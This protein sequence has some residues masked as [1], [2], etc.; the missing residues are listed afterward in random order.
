MS[1]HQGPM[2][3]WVMTVHVKEDQSCPLQY[4]LATGIARRYAAALVVESTFQPFYAVR[5]AAVRCAQKARTLYCYVTCHRPCLWA[6]AAHQLVE[7]K[8]ASYRP[9]LRRSAI[10]SCAS[11]GRS[12]L[13]EPF[14][15]ALCLATDFWTCKQDCSP[16]TTYPDLPK[17]R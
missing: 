3:W 13:A 4:L 10:C 16:H 2:S 17:Y 7:W 14:C 9:M 11:K 12:C 5:I 15:F 6:A 8:R 1:A